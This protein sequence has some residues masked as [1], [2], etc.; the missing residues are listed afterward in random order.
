MINEPLPKL[1]DTVEVYSVT[2]KGW[3]AAKVVEIPM[4]DLDGFD[5]VVEYT[6]SIAAVAVGASSSFV[7][8]EGKRKKK[9][10]L[11]DAQ[12][13][14]SYATGLPF[15]APGG[16][17]S[18]SSLQSAT[19]LLPPTELEQQVI[20]QYLSAFEQ[21]IRMRLIWAQRSRKRAA[22]VEVAESLRLVPRPSP[23]S[24][25]E[26]VA[27]AEAR[28]LDISLAKLR[29]ATMRGQNQTQGKKRRPGAAA[30]I[31][32]TVQ[33]A[34]PPH[35]I[36]WQLY[37]TLVHA[38]YTIARWL[39][40]YTAAHPHVLGED[41]S[42]AQAPMHRQMIED[43]WNRELFVAISDDNE[44]KIRQA[45]AAGAAINSARNL[46]GQSALEAALA[47]QQLRAAFTVLD[48]GARCTGELTPDDLASLGP[49][50][51]GSALAHEQLA[52]LRK[53]IE[54]MAAESGQ[55]S[56]CWNREAGELID[57]LLR[58][59]PILSQLVSDSLG[60]IQPPSHDELAKLKASMAEI[61]AAK[62]LMK[63]SLSPE[64]LARQEARQALFAA[65][66][67]ARHE[68]TALQAMEMERAREAKEAAAEAEVELEPES[69][70]ST[71]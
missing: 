66:K 6:A 33:A 25:T 61:K 19:S 54:A 14:R 70:E 8:T 12:L 53:A 18:S 40:D 55:I 48:C 15:E 16:I 58:L 49:A 64:A 31:E 68:R 71:D 29:A 59:G 65:A 3:V 39:E 45:A 57:P 30:M 17:G 22:A 37:Q 56:L 35:E 47:Q 21:D 23:L 28:D 50:S 46:A 67:H 7:S 4:A 9:V 38:E 36:K 51:G 44:R 43:K 13:C 63:Q 20:S 27:T 52:I 69:T 34:S 32:V 11:F 60:W 10:A 41:P 42:D 26:L 62:Y 2:A 5:V 1:G 24:P